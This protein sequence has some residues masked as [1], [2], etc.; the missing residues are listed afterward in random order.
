MQ[1]NATPTGLRSTCGLVL[2]IEWHFFKHQRKSIFWDITDKAEVKG[3][4]LL[5]SPSE[6]SPALLFFD[7]YYRFAIS[8]H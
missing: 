7:L 2:C 4:S 5:L 3:R 6:I 8:E 1:F